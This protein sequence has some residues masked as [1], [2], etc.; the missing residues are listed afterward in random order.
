VVR[1]TIPGLEYSLRGD[2]TLTVESM[3]PARIYAAKYEILGDKFRVSV[4]DLGNRPHF[5][6]ELGLRGVNITCLEPISFD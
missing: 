5:R 6:S 3:Q 2:A 4:V 1:Y